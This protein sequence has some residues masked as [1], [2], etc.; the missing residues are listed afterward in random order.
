A[1]GFQPSIRDTT[2]LIG[3][4]SRDHRPIFLFRPTGPPGAF[5]RIGGSSLHS[6][7]EEGQGLWGHRRPT[8]PPSAPHHSSPTPFVTLALDAR[9]PYLWICRK[10]P[11]SKRGGRPESETRSIRLV[12]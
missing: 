8:G 7:S 11:R 6:P 4:R 2:K 9:A 10:H 3:R 12:H 1:W 5:P